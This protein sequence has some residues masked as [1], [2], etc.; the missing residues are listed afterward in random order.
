MLH[1]PPFSSLSMY[2]S[3]YKRHPIFH[4]LK[5]LSPQNA[6]KNFLPPKWQKTYFPPKMA[7]VKISASFPHGV[8]APAPLQIHTN[9]PRFTFPRSAWT[10]LLNNCSNLNKLCTHHISSGN[11]LKLQEMV[12][13]M[14]P[15][16]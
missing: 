11:I 2:I 13:V 1:F 14:C 4:V 10:M 5:F 8:D 7:M 16:S 12:L 6:A 15:H 9:R 3:P